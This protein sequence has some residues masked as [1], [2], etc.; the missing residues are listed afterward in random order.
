[1]F[2]PDSNVEILLTSDPNA[3][4][5][6]RNNNNNNKH[7]VDAHSTST[8][9][10]H[11]SENEVV[12]E[13]VSVEFEPKLKCTR[14]KLAKSL[15]IEVANGKSITVDSI[16]HDCFLTLNDHVFL[17][18]LIPM[19]LG[20]FNIIVGI[21]WL[22]KNHAEI[23][24]HEKFVRLPLPPGDTYTSLATDHQRGKGKDVSDVPMVHDFPDVFPEDQPGPP[25]SLSVDFCIDLIP[26]ATPVAKA[27]YRL[28]PSKM[29][30]LSSQ[31]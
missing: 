18:D 3:R 13:F 11:K 5:T 26:G 6:T 4:K 10:K 27:P 15:T 1:M 30:D 25:S 28:A 20:S 17:I 7:H 14:L 8:R 12:N 21:D 29:Q 24:C 22:R 23:A 9:I 16:L 19:Q 2:K 31:L